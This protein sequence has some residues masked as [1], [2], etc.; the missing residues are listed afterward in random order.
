MNTIE[1]HF[2][3]ISS[4][5][6]IYGLTT[7]FTGESSHKILV[8]SSKRKVYCIEY[9]K[10]QQSVIF[11][12]REVQ[13]TYIPGGAEIISMD[14]F[15]QAC[16]EHDFVVG[17]TFTK[18]GTLGTM[19]QYFNIYSDWEPSNKCDLD[20]IAQGCLSICLEFIP[21]HLTHTELIVDGVKEMVWLLS[22]SDLKIHL[23]RE[24]KTRQTYC[25]E[26][27]ITCFPEF[28]AL[29]SLVMWMD[30]FTTS[31]SRLTALGCKDG[32]VIVTSVK[33]PDTCLQSSWK[34]QHDG[35]VS[36]VRLF[37]DSDLESIPNNPFCH[38]YESG[39]INLCVGNTIEVSVV[40]RD[41]LKNGLELA[42]Q[43]LLP[44]SSKYDCVTCGLI[45]DIDM[46]G[47]NEVILGT[48]GQKLLVYKW[49]VNTE[50]GKGSYI[51]CHQQMFPYPLLVLSYIDI[52]GDGVKELLILTTN[53]LHILQHDLTKIQD[54]CFSRMKWISKNIP[55]EKLR[56]YLKMDEKVV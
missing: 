36:V 37:Q 56:E 11:S 3:G 41:I 22:G 35:P 29:D 13:F 23:Y 8:A 51:L 28:A 49:K 38:K 39:K 5:S 31:E 16:H 33:L 17:I 2:C 27:S 18:C 44:N 21:F 12:T 1:A 43:E 34:I 52:I 47:N 24:D 45:A 55:N 26:P 54:V 14:A 48:Y 50:N 53:G 15:N 30:F 32:Y 4:Q 20:N 9:S 40:Y 46:D 7:L 42:S 25:E 10:N 19:S 6:S